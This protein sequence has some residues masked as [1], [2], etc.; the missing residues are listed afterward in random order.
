MLR[1]PILFCDFDGTLAADDNTVSS[2]NRAAIQDYVKRGGMF[3]LATGRLFR[4]ARPLAVDLGLHGPIIACQG[5]GVYDIDSGAC[6]WSS[7][8]ENALAVQVAKYLES[9]PECVPMM[10]LDDMCCTVERNPYTDKFVQICNI[11]YRTTGQKLSE[12]LTEHPDARPSKLLALVHPK[13]AQALC[14][15]GKAQLGDAVEF[16]RS[17][18]S[19]VEIMPPYANKGLACKFLCEKYAI[20]P[21]RTIAMGDSENDLSMIQFAGLGI[22][23]RNAFEEVRARADQVVTD[24]NDN[25][26]AQVIERWG[27]EEV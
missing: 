18:A 5:A 21:S 14:A 27:K 6:L 23:V 15:D 7:T 11:P 26:V 10:Y 22:A 8:L 19:I 20:D 16:C 25:A 9:R 3:V 2:A 24:N 12:Y 13:D 17:Q 1:Y 4:S